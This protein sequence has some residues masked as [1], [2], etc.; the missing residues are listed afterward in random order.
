MITKRLSCLLLGAALAAP[1]GAQD[2]GAKSEKASAQEA[3]AKKRRDDLASFVA[4]LEAARKRTPAMRI[5]LS[6]RGG[7]PDPQKGAKPLEAKALLRLE[8]LEEDKNGAQQRWSRLDVDLSTPL[9][10]L[11]TEK[12]RTPDGIRIHQASEL[13]GEKWYS[14]DRATMLRLDKAARVFGRSGP[15]P[16]QSA[17]RP[18]AVVGADLVR[19]LSRSYEL[20][21]DLPAEIDGEMC[22]SIVG[23][24]RRAKGSESLDLPR[25]RPDEVRLFFSKKSKLLKRMLQMRA[26]RVLHSIDVRDAV[27]SDSIPKSRFVLEAPRGARFVDVFDDA[28]GSLKIRK[29]LQRLDAYERAQKAALK[30]KEGGRADKR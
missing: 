9:G 18:S 28:L 25:E 23:R 27:F 26:G 12:V 8:A 15:L 2:A 24:L 19:G 10:V 17:T 29:D 7:I 6:F 21:L 22:D 13:T 1:L 3:A 14:I 4:S 11:R 16:I 20:G 5:L 30:D